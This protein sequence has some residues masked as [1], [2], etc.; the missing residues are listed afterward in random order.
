[1]VVAECDVNGAHY[2]LV[3]EHV[4]RQ[5]RSLVCA[6]P[7]LGNGKG[8]TTVWLDY[9]PEFGCGLPAHSCRITVFDID[10]QGL[11][12]LAHRPQG[13]VKNDAAMRRVLNR[14]DERLAGRKVSEGA[15]PPKIA[16]VCQSRAPV[17]EEGNV[18]A[19]R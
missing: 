18:R 19:G 11:G 13:A 9:R 14:C 7:E 12:E 15:A 16:V 3:F 4:A 8:G 6:D 17:D 5:L 2:L 1:M 10:R